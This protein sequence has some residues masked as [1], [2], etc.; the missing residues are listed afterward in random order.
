MDINLADNNQPVGID[1]AQATQGPDARENFPTTAS[2]WNYHI[3]I[4]Q[5]LK[6]IIDTGATQ[7]ILNP[8]LCNPK[9]RIKSKSVILKTLQNTIKTTTIYEV[10]LSPEIGNSHQK[11]ELIE[12]KFHDLYDGI[13]G[14]DFLKKYGGIIDYKNDELIINGRHIPLL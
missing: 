11:M 6:F 12:C 9:W 10:P 14:N 13:L 5:K 4:K 7:S 3:I 8:I 1:Q 2:E